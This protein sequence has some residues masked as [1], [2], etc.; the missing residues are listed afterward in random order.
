VCDAA[1]QT[2]RE[3]AREVAKA[4]GAVAFVVRDAFTEHQLIGGSERVA[5]PRP[6]R[7]GDQRLRVL[8]AAESGAK[9]RLA[10]VRCIGHRVSS[11]L[12]SP[13]SL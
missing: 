6:S 11:C 7:P 12:E 3:E 8:A 5:E 1:A 13:H 4:L 10:R 2:R 9:N